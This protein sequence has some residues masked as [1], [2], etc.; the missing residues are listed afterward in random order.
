MVGLKGLNQNFSFL[1]RT[2][3]PT[4]NLTQH[5]ITAFMRPKVWKIEY[6]ICI[7]YPNEHYIF[8]IQTLHYHLSTHQNLNAL[9]VKRLDDFVKI[10]F[11]TRTVPVHSTYSDF[12]KKLVNLFF[13]LLG[14][15][16]LGGQCC[17][18]TCV[19]LGGLRDVVS[20]IVAPQLILGLVI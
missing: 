16:P 18:S 9:L 8:K 6:V 4:R 1:I 13:N 11:P 12:G 20:T 17:H 3:R 5:L 7:D 15:Y 10:P 19:T 2:T 14:T